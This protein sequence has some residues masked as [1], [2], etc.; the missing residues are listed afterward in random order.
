M[1][2]PPTAIAG[3]MAIK[4]RHPQ[5]LY[6]PWVV[7][8]A[9]CS[10]KLYTENRKLEDKSVLKDS[11]SKKEKMEKTILGDTQQGW[12]YSPSWSAEE[13]MAWELYFWSI[14]CSYFPALAALS[15]LMVFV[16]FFL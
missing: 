3:F 10:E 14:S 16:H 9:T 2:S 13:W 12:A 8:I 7:E 1:P 6:S 5:S 11:K 4:V 15:L